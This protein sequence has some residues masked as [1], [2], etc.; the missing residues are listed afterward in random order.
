M[1]QRKFVLLMVDSSN[2]TLHRSSTLNEAM[3]V[4]NDL[5]AHFPDLKLCN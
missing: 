3:S 5:I 1:I 2:D 4:V